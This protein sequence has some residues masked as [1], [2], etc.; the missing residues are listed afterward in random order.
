MSVQATSDGEGSVLVTFRLPAA[1][2]ATELHVVGEFN[3]W[4]TTA[5]SDD[6]R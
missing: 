1:V 3:D 5:A 2:Q 4:S 6:R